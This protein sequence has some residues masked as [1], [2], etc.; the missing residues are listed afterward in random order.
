VPKP[1][2]TR[3]VS[4]PQ[5]RAYLEKAEEY[6]AAASSELAARRS[7][8]ATSLAIHAAINAAD[9]VTGARMGRRAAG[10]DHDQVL[11]LLREAGKDGAEV[12]QNLARLL[13]L[14]TKTEYE[15]DDISQSAATRAVDRASK[16]VAVARR[17]V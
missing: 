11:A 13:P 16:C 17:L 3:E 1:S 4:A 6:L 7:I 10:Q 9:A 5:V 12:E 2:R 14:K 15:P 8:A